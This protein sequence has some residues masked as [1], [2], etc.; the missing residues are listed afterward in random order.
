MILVTGA[1]GFI[2]RRV[3]ARLVAAGCTVRC[4]VRPAY[5]ERQWSP[6]VRVHV[7]AGDLADAPALRVALQ[8][9]DTI[10]HLAG[11][12]TE[13]GERTFE[14]VNYRGTLNLVEA[15]LEVGTGRIVFMSYP[16]AD[17]MARSPFAQ[18]RPG[19][20]AIKSS[21]LDYT[22]FAHPWCTGRGPVDDEN[23][24]GAQVCSIRL[25]GCRRWAN[26][27]SAAVG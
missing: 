11:L 3:V 10:I 21:G 7:V 27:L 18:Q 5:K 9:V 17:R 15:A 16:A 22:I 19:E 6:G 12:W 25:S 20:E 1:N 4:L 2:G 26:A 8:D 24:L 14:S 13:S 23:R